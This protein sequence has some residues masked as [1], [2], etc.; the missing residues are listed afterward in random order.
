MR[1]TYFV[2]CDDISQKTGCW[3]LIVAQHITAQSGM[4]HYMSPRLRV[5]APG[6]MEDIVN[7]SRLNCFPPST[8]TLNVVEKLLCHTCVKRQASVTDPL[9]SSCLEYVL[10]KFRL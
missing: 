9:L 5:D 4:V 1:L 3:L 10:P 8:R 7:D 2:K 6:E